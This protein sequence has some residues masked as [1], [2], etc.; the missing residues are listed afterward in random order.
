MQT[1]D[2]RQLKTNPSVALTAARED[3]MVVV[4]TEILDI[5]LQ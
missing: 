1:V 4:K 2:I 5:A 3:D